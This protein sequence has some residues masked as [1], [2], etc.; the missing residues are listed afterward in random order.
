MNNELKN[1]YQRELE[2]ARLAW[3]K[4]SLNEAFTHLERAHVLGQRQFL[5]HMQVHLWMLRIGWARRDVR[6]VAGQVA[7]LFLTPL[8][9]MTG[10]L[11]L[12]NTGGANVSAFQPMPITPE[13]EALLK[14]QSKQ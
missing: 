1:A 11:P 8:G 2:N 4:R 5:P 14:Q 3:S 12:G 9:H 6:E 10:R 13:L 7:R